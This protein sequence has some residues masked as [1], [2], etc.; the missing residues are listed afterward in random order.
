MLLLSLSWLMNTPF[1][2]IIKEKTYPLLESLQ[3]NFRSECFCNL[4]SCMSKIVHS[5]SVMTPMIQD[6]KTVIV[7]QQLPILYIQAEKFR[8]SFRDHLIKYGQSNGVA[9]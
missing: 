5:C 2:I 1:C 7:V 4:L 3:S 8:N 6:F 9:S